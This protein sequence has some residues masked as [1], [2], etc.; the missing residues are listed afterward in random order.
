MKTIRAFNNRTE[1]A[2][3]EFKTHVIEFFGIG[4]TRKIIELAPV[5]R[6]STQWMA[7]DYQP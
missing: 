6:L 3:L 1:V 2:F 7:R 4:A 5:Q